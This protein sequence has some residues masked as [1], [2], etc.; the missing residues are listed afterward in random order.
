MVLPPKWSST[1]QCISQS[2][3]FKS[4]IQIGWLGK[5]HYQP[6]S[7]VLHRWGRAGHVFSWDTEP[8]TW[9]QDSQIRVQC[10]FHWTTA[11]TYPHLC[12]YD[13]Y[14]NIS[15][16]YLSEDNTDN[17]VNYL[18]DWKVL[19]NIIS[20]NTSLFPE[21]E[22]HC[23]KENRPHQRAADKQRLS[24]RL[25]FLWP[26]HTKG[27]SNLAA[28]CREKT[29]MRKIHSKSEKIKPHL[30]LLQTLSKCTQ[31]HNYANKFNALWIHKRKKQQRLVS[32]KNIT[33]RRFV[34][35]NIPAPWQCKNIH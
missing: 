9:T 20:S 29:G 28:A 5:R 25:F 12:K 33:K 24:P 15:S 32:L 21:A 19:W 7:T 4:N 18:E 30:S 17:I 3:E 6:L 11:T 27:P 1:S 23:V 13:K 31:R 35:V 34:Q 26:V 8:I 2:I 14:L 22:S 10:S 16:S